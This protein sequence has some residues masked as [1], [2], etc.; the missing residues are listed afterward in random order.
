MTL[1]SVHASIFTFRRKCPVGAMES[2]DILDQR[3]GLCRWER[4]FTVHVCNF[5]NSL[6]ML[7]CTQDTNTVHFTSFVK[8]WLKCIKF[9][10]C[11]CVCACVCD[12]PTLV[13]FMMQKTSLAPSAVSRSEPTGGSVLSGNGQTPVKQHSRYTQSKRRRRSR[14]QHCWGAVHFTFVQCLGKNKIK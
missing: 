10:I 8:G 2:G 4:A 11:V 7:I 3:C 5:L 12:L 6:V 9:A 13:S 1:L 14:S